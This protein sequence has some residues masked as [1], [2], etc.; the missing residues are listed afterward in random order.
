MPFIYDSIGRKGDLGLIDRFMSL[1][2]KSGSRPWSV[3]EECFR[4]WESK[5]PKEYQSHLIYLNDI[6]ETRKD[7]K[8]AS[9]KDKVTGGYL[10]YTLDIPSDV[11]KMIRAVYS[12]D[13][14]PMNREFFHEFAQKF[15]KYRVA[16]K[17]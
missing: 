12:V 17:M 1:K 10:R 2:R 13:E 9:T 8:F 6:R 11:M 3:I 16:E 7:R 4:V 15:P 5:K 14:L